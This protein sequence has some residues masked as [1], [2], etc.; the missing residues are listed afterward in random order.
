MF[1]EVS[2]AIETR[3]ATQWNLLNPTIDV[4]YENTGQQA[5]NGD[6]FLDLVILYG[7]AKRKNIGYNYRNHRLK[8]FIN[9]NVFVPRNTG[10]R[11]ALGY[12]D[13]VAGIFR[14][15]QFDG[16]I[17]LSPSIR[18]MDQDKSWFQVN[19]RTEFWYDEVFTS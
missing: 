15:Q 3:M 9:I 18:E 8:G 14:D 1:A 2:Q 16:V 12:A 17:C 19:I 13:Q 7:E 5:S 4:Y 11:T 6:T 10:S